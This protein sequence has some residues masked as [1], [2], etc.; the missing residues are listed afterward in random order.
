MLRW[1]LCSLAEETGRFR[2]VALCIRLHFRAITA[3]ATSLPLGLN[4]L[5]ILSH[6]QKV[7]RKIYTTMTFV[8]R[9][10]MQLRLIMINVCRFN[11]SLGL[12][13]DDT[14]TCSQ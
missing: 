7:A 5:C 14:Q 11:R 13:R 6:T 1:R 12:G 9:M 4:G 10:V 3:P 2:L 8:S